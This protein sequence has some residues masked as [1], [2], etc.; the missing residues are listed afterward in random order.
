MEEKKSKK[1]N[2][3]N[4]Q[5]EKREPEKVLVKERKRSKLVF[6]KMT[7]RTIV[8]AVCVVI[9]LLLIAFGVYCNANSE[10]SKLEIPTSE[11]MQ[12][13]INSVYREIEK[14]RGEMNQEFDKNNISEEYKR[15]NRIL[16]EK[17][18]RRADLEER[19]YKINNHFYDEIKAKTVGR[20]M[21]FF[22]GGIL[23]IIASLAVSG[24]LF[25]LRRDSNIS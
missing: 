5:T 25:S 9:G 13:E 7:S 18:S 15:M 12:S 11:K 23:I 6:K 4:S 14:I 21:P 3:K 17:E 10:Y 22:V 16:Q 20:S 19:L 2:I 1:D 8:T 24:V